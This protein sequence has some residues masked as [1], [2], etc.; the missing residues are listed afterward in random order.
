MFEILTMMSGLAEEGGFSIS[1]DNSLRGMLDSTKYDPDQR[2]T[3]NYLAST[4]MVAHI[5]YSLSGMTPNEY[6]IDA[7]IFMALG[8]TEPTAYTW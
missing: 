4:H 1:K 3:F 7:G 6:A 8:I 5:I 2:G